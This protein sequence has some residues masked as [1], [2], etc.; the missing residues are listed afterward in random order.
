MLQWLAVNSTLRGDC[1]RH[2]RKVIRRH[3][4]TS[5]LRPHTTHQLHEK[6]LPTWGDGRT[7]PQQRC[8]NLA[9][10]VLHSC[11]TRQGSATRADDNTQHNYNSSWEHV[12]VNYRLWFDP[13]VI[14]DS[15]QQ[16][17]MP[18]P[19]HT[20]ANELWRYIYIIRVTL[21]YVTRVV[22]VFGKK[23]AE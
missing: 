6:Y 1:R 12:L 3:R 23:M 4:V 2:L 18:A 11:A 14:P 22:V 15:D 7:L 5:V 8:V 13:R 16:A 17:E 20:S 9:G 10:K 21:A 19:S